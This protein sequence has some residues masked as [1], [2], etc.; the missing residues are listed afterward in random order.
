MTI[1]SFLFEGS[2][3]D[4]RRAYAAIF[5]PKP[6]RAPQDPVVYASVRTRG[7]WRPVPDLSRT[8]PAAGSAFAI[9]LSDPAEGQRIFEALAE[10]G[11]VEAPYEPSPWSPGFGRLTDRFGT[12]WMV[13]A[14]PPPRG[15][16]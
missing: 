8:D 9:T 15:G 12:S 7:G 3:E 11:H 5:R 10:G 6:A 1:P 16:A 4:A 13:D 14:M 2:C